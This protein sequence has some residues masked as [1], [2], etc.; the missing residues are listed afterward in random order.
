MASRQRAVTTEF[1]ASD[2]IIQWL[3]RVA[4]M[5]AHV[6]G[7]YGGVENLLQHPQWDTAKSHYVASLLKA[8][9]RDIGR[10]SSEFTE[11]VQDY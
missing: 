7:E 2:E 1:G 8:L 5:L 6:R 10:I 3:E 4:G 11:H 9:K